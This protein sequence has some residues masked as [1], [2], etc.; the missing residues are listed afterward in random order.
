MT[1]TMKDWAVWYVRAHGLAVFPLPPN[2]KAPG[3]IGI[4]SAS[5]DLA[6]ISAWWDAEP[7]ANIGVI[8]CLRIDI[9]P[10]HGGDTAWA[11]LEA[12]YGAL[13]TLTV[14]TPSGGTHYYLRAALDVGNSRGQLPRGI[15]VRG[16][17]AGYTVAPPSYTT[18]IPNKQC[19]GRYVL[20]D[21]TAPIAQCPSWLLALLTPAERPAPT[22]AATQRTDITQE[23]LAD[24]R[25]ALM[26]PELLQDWEKWSDLGYALLGL[27]ETGR[28]LF[29]EYSA[30]QRL[31]LPDKAVFETEEIWW[32]NH[33]HASPRSDYRAIFSRAQALGWRNPKSVDPTRLGFG[34]SPLPVSAALAPSPR[35]KFEVRRGWD[36]ANA[37]GIKWRVDKILPELGIAQV[38]GPPSA[39]KSF[40]MLDLVMSIVRGIPYGHA[41]WATE[42]TDVV[43]VL[44]EGSAGF[45][46][47]LRA[48]KQFN[49]LDDQ[50]PAPFIIADSPNLFD[51]ADSK[52]LLDAVVSSGA[53]VAVIDTMAASMAGG[54]ENSAKDMGIVLSH[55]RQIA[56]AIG[57]LVFLVHHTGKN[58][59]QGSRGSSIIPG[60][61]ETQ[62]EIEPQE[63]GTRHVSIYKQR[64]GDDSFRWQFKLRSYPTAGPDGIEDSAVVMHIAPASEA[65]TEKTIS[66]KPLT[67]DEVIHGLLMANAGTNQEEGIALETLIASIMSARPDLP[68]A[69]IGRMITR[70][71]NSGQLS[72]LSDGNLRAVK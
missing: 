5:L 12:Q 16:A 46:Q 4:K 1:S 35:Q 69:S 58:A 51:P 50:A 52:L 47:R 28:E 65:V 34:L 72:Y 25:N 42:R 7:S 38:Y 3:S 22:H 37:P 27:G 15:D 39:G 44:A 26:S 17:N 36:F 62:I 64:D 33:Q 21:Q 30:A 56:A 61:M 24:L 68:S 54:D 11:A 71:I 13:Q 45:R 8:G 29:F 19:E 63:D 6:Q 14:R 43:Y 67:N 9:D 48:Y 18:E 40:M 2:K 31:A 49:N 23:Q 60:A 53:K 59:A 55:C 66:D 70:T 20:V 41:Q 57:G 10:K 32:R